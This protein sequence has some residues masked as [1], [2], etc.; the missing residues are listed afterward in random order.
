MY[1]SFFYNCKKIYF[2]N[3]FLAVTFSGVSG[4]FTGIYANGISP[5]E[6]KNDIDNVNKRAM[7]VYLN[8]IGYT[9]LGLISG[10]TYPV[11]FPLYAYYFLDENPSKK[12]VVNNVK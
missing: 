4:L 6:N 9:S 5:E 8:L 7:K 2:E 3:L 1:R 11:S 12:P 10:V